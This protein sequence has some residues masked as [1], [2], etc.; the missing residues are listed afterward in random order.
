[1]I[2]F[3]ALSMTPV[4]ASTLTLSACDETPDSDEI[5]VP[6][7]E[8]QEESQRL[9]KA[10]M[11]EKGPVI[12]RKELR[13]DP[14][15]HE[16]LGDDELEAKAEFEKTERSE[17]T[18]EVQFTDR[19]QG[20]EIVARI[21]GAEPG[22]HGFHIHENG[23]CSDL[24]GKSMGGH[25]NPGQLPHALPTEDG[26][27]HLG[28]LGNIEIGPNGRGT[29]KAAVKDASLRP[30]QNSTLILR[31]VVVHSGKDQGSTKQPSGDAGTPVAC[32]VIQET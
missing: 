14:A 10:S 15:V 5:E 9:E 1:M 3:K 11:S 21:Q 2:R 8:A 20:V 31:S 26:P 7:F 28:D 24:A 6:P 32:A 17:I 23:D 16:T 29:L 12:Q 4:I 22:K 19:G 25:F 18:G 30:T 13:D 27:R